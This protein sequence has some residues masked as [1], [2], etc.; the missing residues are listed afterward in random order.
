MRTVV[1]FFQQKKLTSFAEIRDP[2]DDDDESGLDK[3]PPPHVG[4]ATKTAEIKSS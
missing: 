3:G 1:N 4:R 2:V